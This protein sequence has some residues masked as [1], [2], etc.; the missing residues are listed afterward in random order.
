VAR[1]RYW[2]T[3]LRDFRKFDLE[4][5]LDAAL[6]FD[7]AVQNGGID[8]AKEAAIRRGLAAAPGATG[9]S[10]REIFANAIAEE[11]NPDFVED[12]RSRRLT[13]A[14]SQGKV[15]GALYRVEDWGLAQLTADAIDLV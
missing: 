2:A 7:T 13:I 3:A 6:M 1:D 12:V 10:R 11:S 4:D 14:R 8:G 5:E 15:H 9:Q